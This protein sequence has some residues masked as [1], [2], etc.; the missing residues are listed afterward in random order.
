MAKLMKVS[1]GCSMLRIAFLVFKKRLWK[2]IGRRISKSCIVLTLKITSS[3]TK[4][5]LMPGL[6]LCLARCKMLMD[7]MK[8]MFH[9]FNYPKYNRIECSHPPSVCSVN[10]YAGAWFWFTVMTTVG[11]GK[12]I[13]LQPSSTHCQSCTH[14]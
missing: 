14:L 2:K 11:Y 9:K 5:F 4:Q 13:E 8:G 10:Y 3:K 7:L 6:M 1:L 12:C